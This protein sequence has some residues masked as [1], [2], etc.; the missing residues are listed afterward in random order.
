[1]APA[2][3]FEVT[4][5]LSDLVVAFLDEYHI[6]ADPTGVGVLEQLPV[7]GYRFTGARPR[8]CRKFQVPNFK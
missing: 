6:S 5:I 2:L 1:M 4:Q 7:S 3:K 8:Q